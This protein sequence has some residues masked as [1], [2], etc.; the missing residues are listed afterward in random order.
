MIRLLRKLSNLLPRQALITIYKVFVRPYGQTFN[1][2]FHSKM[3]RIQY[4]ACLAIIGAIR[5]TSKKKKEKEKKVF[6]E[7]ALEST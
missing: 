2:Y 3:E 5:G 4:N 1:N 7:L 6:Q